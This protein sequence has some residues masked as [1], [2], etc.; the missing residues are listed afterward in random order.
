MSARTPAEAPAQAALTSDEFAAALRA[1]GEERYHHRHP[2]NVRMHQGQ[3]SRRAIQLWVANRYYY[4]TRIPIKDGH[5]LAKSPEAAFRREWVQRLH[6]HDGRCAGEGG[7]ELWLQL[8]EAVGLERGRVERLEG[9]LPGVRRACDAYVEFVDRHDLL[10]AVASSLTE[11]FAGFIMLDRIAAFEKHYPWVKPDGLAYFK[12]RTE[13]A[14]RDSRYGLAFVTEHA[15]SREDQERCLAALRRKC[16]ILWNLLDAV[17]RAASR[18]RLVSHALVRDEPDGSSM[19]VL[20]ERA[21][22]LRGSS[23]EMLE[24]CDG[25]R[26]GS[27][28]ALRMCER[29]PGSAQIAGDVHDFLQQ[30]DELRALR[31]DPEVP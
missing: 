17:E 12:S 5:I 14:P 24:L 2:F 16:E 15:R 9:V 26:T 22:R 13:Q 7:L 3:L 19:L 4:Q 1:V 10:E 8:A 27:D 6:D 20:P 28:V 31:F 18:P 21:L 23:R 25:S 29:H 11:L 30:L